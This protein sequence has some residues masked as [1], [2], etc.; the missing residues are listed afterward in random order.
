MCALVVL[1]LLFAVGAEAALVRVGRIVLRADGGFTPRTL[2]RHDY[3]PIE[4]QGHAD[5]ASTD[6]GPVPALSRIRLEFDRDG[7]LNNRGLAICP[8]ERI[9]GA[10]AKGARRRCGKAVVV[11][12]PL[13]LFNGPSLN[14]RPTAVAHALATFPTRE[15]HVVVIPVEYRPRGAFAYTVTAEIPEIA[16]GYGALTHV[17][18]KIGRRYRGGGAWRSY[19]SGRCSDGIFETRGRLDFVEGTAIEGTLYKPCNFRRS[20]GKRL[21]P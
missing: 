8:P 19:V 2:P 16:D 18:A 13:S 21:Q 5:V 9:D 15:V 20:R 6:S 12:S 11:R 14:G 3:V 17:D 4:F 1:C 10:S 7:L